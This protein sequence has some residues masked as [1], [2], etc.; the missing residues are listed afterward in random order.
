MLLH[1]A[2]TINDATDIGNFYQ[3]V[4][5]FSLLRQFSIP[6]E[7]TQAIFHTD[8]ATDVYLLKQESLQLEI[9]ISNQQEERIFSH[10]C[11]AYPS[12]RLLYEKAVKRGYPAYVRHHP[13][14]DTFFIRDKSGNLFEI[15]EMS[16]KP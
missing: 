9:F 1:L 14:S 16:V 15:K 12:A 2:L 4:L 7:T 5:S 3:E 8:E 11:L 13:V 10:L 6:A